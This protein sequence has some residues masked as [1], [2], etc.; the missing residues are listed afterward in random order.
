MESKKILLI[1]PRL[2]SGDSIICDIPLS[3]LYAATHSV[4][5]GYDVDILDL[6]AVGKGDWKLEIEKRL[7]GVCLVGMSVMTGTPIANA[8]K[9]TKYIKS[10]SSVPMVWGGPHCTVDPGRTLEESCIDYVVRGF[11]SETL[12]ELVS[13]IADGK[14]RL[15]E[16]ENL[17]FKRDGKVVHNPLRSHVELLPLEDIPYDLI[18]CNDS[19]YTRMNSSGGAY[20]P[21]LLVLAARIVALS[22]CPLSNIHILRNVG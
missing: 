18:D 2:G 14:V 20:S 6:R 7:K 12:C 22:V 1:Y 5:A 16:I 3:L 11:G 9:L 4:K 21:F 19:V 15:D 13:H 8:L 10:I 17:S